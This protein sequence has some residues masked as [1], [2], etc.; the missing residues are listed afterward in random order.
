[1]KSPWWHGGAAAPSEDAK[2][3]FG[4]A[5]DLFCAGRYGEAL[6]IFDSLANEF[7]GNPDIESA[8][9]Q[10]IGG[11]GRSPLSLPGPNAGRTGEGELDAETVKRIVLDKMLNGSSDAVQLQAAE[12]AGRMLGLFHNGRVPEPSTQKNEETEQPAKEE[13]Q[14]EPSE[15]VALDELTTAA[16]QTRDTDHEFMDAPASAFAPESVDEDEVQQESQV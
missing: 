4:H 2:Q 12:L 1:M 9:T 16:T 10:C 6:A 13:G 14:E 5:A 3:R 15:P 11:H 8:R 7:P